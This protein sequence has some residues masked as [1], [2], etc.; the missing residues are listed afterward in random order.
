MTLSVFSQLYETK[1]KKLKQNNI[2]KKYHVKSSIR[3]FA[4]TLFNFIRPTQV[5]GRLILVI[6]VLNN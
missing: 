4:L 1:L 2:S 3:K 5:K 6:S